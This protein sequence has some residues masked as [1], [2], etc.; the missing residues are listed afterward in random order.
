MVSFHSR[1]A[2]H[3]HTQPLECDEQVERYALGGGRDYNSQP[4]WLRCDCRS[5]CRAV[6]DAAGQRRV[7]PSVPLR[8]FVPRFVAVSP[9]GARGARGASGQGV[10]STR[11]KKGIGWGKALWYLV[12][13]RTGGA[14]RR[15]WLSGYRLPSV[16]PRGA[17]A[18]GRPPCSVRLGLSAGIRGAWT[19]EGPTTLQQKPKHSNASPQTPRCGASMTLI[20]PAAASGERGP[21]VAR[22]PLRCT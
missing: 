15:A 6:N 20:V 19:G 2:T 3:S 16:L 13:G 9:G 17:A 7:T 10:T 4:S 21:G 12:P 18:S 22:K 1:S 11:T 5:V 8:T 14:A